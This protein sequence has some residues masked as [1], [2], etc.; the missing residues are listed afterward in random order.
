MDTLKR[1]HLADV[2]MTPEQAITLAEILPE[3]KD[4]A[5]INLLENPKLVM[6]A[7][8]KTE[9]GQEEACALYASLLAAARVSDTLV[10]IDI[11]NPS[12]ESG[13]I[14]KALANQV[15]AYCLH[16]VRLVPDIGDNAAS[17]PILASTKYP[18]VLR[19]IVGHEDDSLP[20]DG[21]DDGN[22]APDEDYVIGGTGVV[23]ALACVLKNV[24]D[25]SSRQS[26][27][28]M[29]EVEN[30]AVGPRPHVPSGKA[31][32]MSKH[33]LASA[34]KIHVRLTPA[35]ARAK[36][37]SHKDMNNYSEFPPSPPPT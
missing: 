35:L 8:A 36:A 14:V 11:D 5:H 26:G 23:K 17:E 3:V 25:D 29:R 19:H 16:N 4:L 6:L 10:K 33:L 20:M 12:A 37:A 2:A 18:D 24:G 28:F 30:G 31:K 13:E 34:R 21:I 22:D 32:D 27:E 1:L 9:D 15:V 7:D